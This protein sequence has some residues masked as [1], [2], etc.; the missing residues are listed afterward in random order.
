MKE[1]SIIARKH[2]VINLFCLNI[3]FFYDLLLISALTARIGIK[4]QSWMHDCLKM[5]NLNF[6]TNRHKQKE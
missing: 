5:R 1:V 2:L 4:K 6:Q 3:M